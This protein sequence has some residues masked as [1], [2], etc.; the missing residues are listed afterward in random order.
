MSRPEFSRPVRLRQIDSRPVS[1]TATEEERA[2]LARR[3]GIRAIDRLEAEIAL[4][5]DGDRVI[6]DGTMIADI[7]QSCAVSG[8]DLPVPVEEEF[9]L[10]FVPA[11]SFRPPEEG[12]EIEIEI[13]LD[14]D[15]CDEVEYEGDSID[16]GEAVAQTLALAIDPYA[17]GSGADE[18]RAVAG[19]ESDETPRGPLADA[20]AA[21]KKAD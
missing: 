18:A 12:D 1:L 3:F 15:D 14:S 19:I 2:A 10:R 7:V 9:A 8:D 20:L 16:L 17:Q 13:E 6:V 21:L 11:G 4:I 5:R